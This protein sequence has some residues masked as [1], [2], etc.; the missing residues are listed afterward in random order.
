MSIDSKTL[1]TLDLD[2]FFA[3]NDLPVHIATFGG[4]IPEELNDED[5]IRS[6]HLRNKTNGLI[7]SF[8]EIAINPGALENLEAT[9]NMFERLM[10]IE[11]RQQAY[12]RTFVQMAR[13]GYFSYDRQHDMR[14][15]SDR[16]KDENE[17][18]L[19]AYPKQSHNLIKKHNL[20][21]YR[22]L[23]DVVTGQDASGAQFPLKFR[24]SL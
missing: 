17:Y 2:V 21:D 6:C 11:E 14:E 12:L 18:I 16:D 10:T 5:Y 20:R 9:Q 15:N 8:E 13:Y 3:F 23:E 1:A 7:F 22:K 4:F 19:V 24:L